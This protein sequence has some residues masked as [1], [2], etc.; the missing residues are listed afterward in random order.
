MR[1][2]ALYVILDPAKLPAG[3]SALAVAEGA[4][5]GG[6]GV[7]QLRDKGASAR[8]LVELARALTGLCERFEARCVINDRLDIALASGAHGAHL[9]PD[10]VPMALARRVAPTLWLGGSAGDAERAR[11]L[12]RDGADY[13]G[14]GALYDARAS[15][16]D[17][18]A[19]RGPKLIR[20][21]CEVVSLPVIGI[22]GVELANAAEVIA[23]GA[24]GVAVIR[25]VIAQPDP[26]Q[27]A[28]A[29]MQ[30]ITQAHAARA[31]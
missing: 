9:G 21:V 22:G 28:R 15:K 3:A 16:P 12:A 6:A 4:L 8:E 19:P 14:C 31:R 5:V 25:A 1:S 17:A 27:S 13:L 30:A 2:P 10:D 23:A 29:L 18:S 11:A 20:E 7:V 24:T 26:E